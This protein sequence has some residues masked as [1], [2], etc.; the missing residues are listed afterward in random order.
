MECSRHKL[1]VEVQPQATRAVTL[2]IRVGACQDP[3]RHE[4]MV[5]FNSIS[6]VCVCIIYR[7]DGYCK[8]STCVKINQTWEIDYA[9]CGLRRTGSPREGTGI[10]PSMISSFGST[11]SQLNFFTTLCRKVRIASRAY[12]FPGQSRGPPPN[13]TYV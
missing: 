2:Q 3:A 13:G 12:S 11:T 8:W 9:S 4:Y 6:G 10:M 7:H 1:D 5:D